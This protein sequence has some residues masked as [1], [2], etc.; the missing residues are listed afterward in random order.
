MCR[1]KCSNG[2]YLAA[3]LLMVVLSIT[4]CTSQVSTS[5]EE[6]TSNE[7]TDAGS[8]TTPAEDG[9]GSR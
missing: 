6:P 9:S 8:G 7:P 4:G 3:I 2:F 1:C 5:G